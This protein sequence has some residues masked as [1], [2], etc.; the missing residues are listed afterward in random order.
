MNR[1][2][3]PNP[4]WHIEKNSIRLWYCDQFISKGYFL[5]MEEEQKASV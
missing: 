4:V 2:L 3:Q 1:K 5:E